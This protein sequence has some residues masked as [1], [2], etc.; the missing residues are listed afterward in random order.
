[1]NETE[2]KNY[3][4]KGWASALAEKHNVHRLTVYRAFKTADLK[5]PI[6][7]DIVKLALQQAEEEKELEE[8]I[9]TLT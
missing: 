7:K 6:Y 8:K 2:V 9:K 1:M 4:P 3:L 5:S